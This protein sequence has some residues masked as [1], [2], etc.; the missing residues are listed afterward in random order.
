MATG[1]L[2]KLQIA[3]QETERLGEVFLDVR[4]EAVA[5]DKLRQ[6]AREAMTAIRKQKA[7]QDVILARPAGVVV[8]VAVPQA[9][10]MLQ[11]D[12]EGYEA[13]LTTLRAE[14]KRLIG[15][16]AEKGAGPGRVGPGMLRAMLNLQD[17][18]GKKK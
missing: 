13:R 14:E 1:T 10:N 8:Q 3:I 6:E 17:P 2:A 16:L 7:T 11:A 4:A 15:L 5:C 9:V 12:L 18:A